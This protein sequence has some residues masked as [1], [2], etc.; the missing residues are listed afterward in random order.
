M[1]CEAIYVANHVDEVAQAPRRTVLPDCNMA[2][3]VFICHAHADLNTALA[4]CAKLEEVGVRCWIAPRNVGA[5]AYARQLVQ[6]IA[7]ARTVLLIFSDRTNSSEHVLREL[8]IAS[9][10]QKVIIPFRIENVAPNED[11]EYFTLRMH[12]LDALNPPME[13]RLDELVAFVQ[14]LLDASP[15]LSPPV[16]SADLADTERREVEAYERAARIE[17]Q[18]STHDTVVERLRGTG[19]APLRFRV[20]ASIAL[21]LVAAGAIFAFQL[22]ARKPIESNRKP[23]PIGGSVS[24]SKPRPVE[25][26]VNGHAIYRDDYLQRLERGSATGSSSRAAVLNQLIQESLV[27]QY[28]RD[29]KIEVSHDEIT[30]RENETKAKYPAGQFEQILKQQG[31]TEQAVQNVFKQQLVL[32]KALAPQVRVSDNDITSYFDKNRALFDKPAQ[33]RARQI[34]VADPAKARE[35]LA[36]LNAGDSWDILAKQYSTDPPSKDKGGELGFFGR[37]EMVPAF[38][39]AAFGATVGQIVGPVKTQFG[40][41]VLQVEEKKPAQKATLATAHD[42]IK[43]QLMAQQ[44]AQKIPPFLQSLRSAATITIVDPKLKGALPP[45]PR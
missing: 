1:V 22:V 17:H 28:A 20:I 12:W 5:G 30:K 7:N 15:V 37:G 14:R 10:R 6:A 3:D 2:H 36:K 25:A 35:V 44:E 9:N 11:L 31:L 19:S 42:A 32:E 21:V 39:D 43:Q 26:I 33:V 38:Q 45:P 23:V 29:H 16:A 27:D 13:S 18:P 34:L 8:E 24:V 4:A 40:Y 41:H